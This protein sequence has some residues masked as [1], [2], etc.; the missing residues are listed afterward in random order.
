MDLLH[1]QMGYDA[2]SKPDPVSWGLRDVTLKWRFVDSQ[3]RRPS[4]PIWFSHVP[5]RPC[6]GG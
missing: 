4:I 1:V 5:G 3:N 2:I 6:A